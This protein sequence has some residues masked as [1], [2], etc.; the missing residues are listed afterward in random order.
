MTFPP[1][2]LGSLGRIPLGILTDVYGGR[3]VFIGVLFC[4]I[5]PAVLTGW[6]SAYWQLLACGFLIG[7]AL[8]SFSVGV[9]FVNGWY[10]PQRQGAAIG[11]YWA[12]NIGQSIGLG[13]GAVFELVPQYWNR[14]NGVPG[15]LYMLAEGDLPG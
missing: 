5:V 15:K 14:V 12:G 11:V 9:G 6:V 4:S 10:P 13:N 3:I 8:A 7:I 2:L 1:V